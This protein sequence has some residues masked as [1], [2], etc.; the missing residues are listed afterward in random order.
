MRIVAGTKVNAS[1]CEDWLAVDIGFS[2]AK[3]TTGLMGQRWDEP[4]CVEYG[5]LLSECSRYAAGRKVLGLIVEAPLSFA[6]S[7]RNNPVGRN[8]EKRNRLTRYWY[9][10]LGCSVMVAAALFLRDLAKMD[11]ETTVHVFEGFIS[12]KVD[13]T[14]HRKDA[15]RLIENRKKVVDGSE[16]KVNPLDR[17]DSV[18]SLWDGDRGIPGLIKVRERRAQY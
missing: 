14:D 12:F 15:V 6:F 2:S 8:F 5:Q 4:K 3:K 18:M 7:S 16:L 9:Q 13:A 1:Q 10:G 17:I 11:G